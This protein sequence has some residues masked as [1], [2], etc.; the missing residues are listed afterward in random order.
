M[1]SRPRP[2]NSTYGSAVVIPLSREELLALAGCARLVMLADGE[3]SDGEIALVEQMGEELGLDDIRWR[4]I[5]DEARETL[6]DKAALE[7]VA[8]VT[9]PEAQ[10]VIYERL[11]V[12]ATDGDIVDSEWDILEWLDETWRARAGG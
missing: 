7:A 2:P 1:T 11:Y 6:K 3:I 12:L 4:G 10:E 8:A 5:W 9:R